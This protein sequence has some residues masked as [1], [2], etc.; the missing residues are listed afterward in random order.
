ML[1]SRINIGRFLVAIFSFMA[2]TAT[3]AAQSYPTRP[4]TLVVPFPAGGTS[5]VIIRFLAERL[6]EKLGQRFVVDNRPGANGT[7]GAASV[8]RSEPDG[9]TILQVSNTNTVAAVHT[10]DQLPYNLVDDIVTVGS[11]YNI[12]TVLVVSND[13]PFNS[14][15]DVLEHAREN[16]GQLSYAW[17]HATAA[18]AGA[19]LR[20]AAEVDVVAVPY[21]TTQPAVIDVLG[22]RVELLFTDIAAALPHIQS[23]SLR[24]L[25]VTGEERS[26]VLPDVPSVR[27]A[28]PNSAT[29]VGWGGL[30]V[31][32]GTPESVVQTLNEALNE[33]FS[34][35]EGTEFLRRNGAEPMLGT[36]ES[37]MAFIQEEDPKWARAIEEAGL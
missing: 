22:G 19:S 9:Y 33:I 26:N 18:V 29:F 27:E 3:A 24:P 25:I 10:I 17:P 7:I 37:F 4:G 21:P 35:E 11:I 1:L 8:L 15:E 20:V 23:G 16:P 5:D 31:P 34:S 36:P 14:V 13:S 6:G 28:V 2:I 30:I 32:S 12:P